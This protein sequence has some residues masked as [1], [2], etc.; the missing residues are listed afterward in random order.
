MTKYNDTIMGGKQMTIVIKSEKLFGNVKA[1]ITANRYSGYTLMV[2]NETESET[3]QNNDIIKIKTYYSET[4]AK[5]A[6]Q[7]IKRE[8]SK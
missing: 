7:R 4:A 1:K 2:Y 8:L 3:L 5:R 6:L